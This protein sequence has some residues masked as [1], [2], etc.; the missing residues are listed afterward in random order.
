MFKND[1]PKMG[2]CKREGVAALSPGLLSSATLGDS[3]AESA[4]PTGLRPKVPATR[5]CHI[6]LFIILDVIAATPLG[7]GPIA[8]RHPRVAEYGNP[9]LRAATHPSGLQ[10]H[11]QTCAIISVTSQT[12][13]RTQTRVLRPSRCKAD[14]QPLESCA[15]FETF[16]AGSRPAAFE[17]A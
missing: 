3:E 9:G 10:P 8:I 15:W 1:A 16:A 5:R 6:S 7:L 13:E 11:T 14:P 4:T 2:A 12:L 17:T